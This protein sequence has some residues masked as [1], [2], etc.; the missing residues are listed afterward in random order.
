[1]VRPHWPILVLAVI[2]AAPAAVAAELRIG[3]A[4]PL[5]GPYAASGERNRAAVQ[6]ALASL[7]QAGGV[8]GQ[9]LGLVAVDDG[10]DADRAPGVAL[11]LIKSGVVFVVGHMCSHASLMAAP[12]YEAAGVPMIS[13]DSTHPQLTEE[14]RGNVFRLIGRDDVQGRMAGDWLAAQRPA[15]RIAIVH[16]GSTY[17][18]GLA[19]RV[20]TRLREHG[21]GET[22][23]T[24]YVPAQADHAGLV[25]Q[26]GA[27]G[28]ELLYL[29]GYGPEAGRIIKAVR[30]RNS[31]L[32]LVGGDG[33]G[34]EEFWTAAGPA[35]EGTVFTTRRDL[36]REPAA[37]KVLAA[38]RALG[39]GDLPSGLAAYAAVEVWA[40][41][42]TRAGTVAPKEVTRVMQHG[43]FATAIGRVEFD[44]KG[45]L[46][47]A[48]WQWQ[49]WR[50]GGHAPLQVTMAIR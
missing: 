2:L 34:M 15:S 16:D 26:L 24:S 4:N 49:I 19:K 31:Q 10:C 30:R 13:P 36:R 28:I 47:D 27:A 48:D 25:E 33:L 3:L 38:F 45:D 12:I 5:S 6:L 14:G 21:L 17:G 22:M 44:A 37:A 39:L 42:A 50:D 8:L 35:G 23:F 46:M 43:R 41:A 11:E 32:R 1:M 18:Q 9:Q 7:N 40:T 20:R 29:G